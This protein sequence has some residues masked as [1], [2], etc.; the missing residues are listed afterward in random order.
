ML[1]KLCFVCNECSTSHC[2]KFVFIYLFVPV[3]SK[4]QA[5]D[6]SAFMLYHAVSVDGEEQ[7]VE[8][9]DRD[10]MLKVTANFDLSGNRGN[11]F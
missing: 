3:L 6:I 10:I 4:F 9:K 2:A 7:Q 1:F 11:V 8:D 5:D